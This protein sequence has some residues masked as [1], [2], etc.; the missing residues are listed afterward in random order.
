M[1]NRVALSSLNASTIDILNVIRANASIEYQSSVPEITTETDI[2]VVGEILYGTPALANQF[3][4]ALINRIA[5]VRVKSATFNNPY[6]RLKKGYL[7]YGESIEDVFVDIAR[8][9]IFSNEKA[10]DRELKQYIPDVKSAFYA[11]NWRTI[12]PV[13]VSEEQ[14]QTAFLSING[15]QDMIARIVD[16]VYRAAEYDEFLLF[17]YML[18]KTISKGKIYPVAVDL[19]NIKNAAVAFRSYSNRFQFMSNKYN[20]YGVKNAA[21]RDRQVI[22][23]DSDFNAQFDVEVLADAFNMDKANFIGSLYLIDDFTTFDNERFATIRAE[24][25]MIEEVTD[26]ELALMANVKAVLLDEDFFQ[27][28][29]NLAKFTEK[30]IASGLRW[31]YFYHT[32]KTVAFSPFANAVVFVSDDATTTLPATFTV[33]VASKSGNANATVFTLAAPDSATLQPEN[34][35]YIMDQT[36]IA[37]GVSVLPYGGVI[38][39][40]SPETNPATIS[41]TLKASI[42]GV[43]YTAGSA[44]TVATA[45][46]ATLTFAPTSNASAGGSGGSQSGGGTTEGGGTEAGGGTTTN[47]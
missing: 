44:M 1:P 12:Y 36:N 13:T 45:V 9:M 46:G 28:Y 31:N 40:E 8:V 7:E 42:N 19:D 32:W 4:N 21:P 34:I 33:T 15:V 20:S 47:P 35:H 25:D 24:S 10:E 37:A 3:I 14:L 2:P 16:G 11:I 18:I 27:I 41:V 30:F 17:K 23:M 29:D 43:E 5:L 39:P 22:F 38:I 26:A 6:A